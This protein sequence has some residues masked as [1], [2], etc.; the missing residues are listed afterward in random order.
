MMALAARMN[1]KMPACLKAFSDNH[2]KA[3][4][5][6]QAIGCP[7]FTLVAISNLDWN[8]YDQAA[9]RTATGIAWLLSR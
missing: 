2:Q 4:E 1:C 9:E 8:H 3:F 5:T 6:A 7:S